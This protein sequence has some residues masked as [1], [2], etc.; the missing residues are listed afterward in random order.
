[1]RVLQGYGT[2]DLGCLAY[3]CTGEGRL[4]PRTPT[5]SWRC[6]I[7]DGP[8]PPRP[9]QPGEVVATIF[10]EAYPLLRLATGDV[11]TLAPDGAVP[12]RADGAE[13]R[14]PARPASATR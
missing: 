13:A 11:S 10:D 14:R 5:R 6:S 1:M 7:R 2:A 4:A 8:R 12:V 9:A 3:E